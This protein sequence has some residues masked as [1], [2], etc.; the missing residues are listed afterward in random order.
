[1]NLCYELNSFFIRCSKTQKTIRFT[2]QDSSSDL[3]F[4]LEIIYLFFDN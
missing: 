4:R 2:I 1:M 3:L